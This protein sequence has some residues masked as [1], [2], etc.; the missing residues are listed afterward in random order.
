MTNPGGVTW[1]LDGR[2]GATRTPAS[3]G[4]PFFR[5]DQNFSESRELGAL[6]EKYIQEGIRDDLISGVKADSTE[7]HNSLHGWSPSLRCGLLGDQRLRQ[8]V[9]VSDDYPA[10]ELRFIRTC[11]ACLGRYFFYQS[12]NSGECET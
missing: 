5:I 9:D 12:W 1:S 7:Q 6:R 8:I 10:N 3:P 11:F 4:P 2:M